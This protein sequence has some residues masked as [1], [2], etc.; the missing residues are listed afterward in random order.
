M[1]DRYTGG[2]KR[3][4]NSQRSSSTAEHYEK[5]PPGTSGHSHR[6][7]GK[8]KKGQTLRD[9]NYDFREKK[10]S[11]ATDSL[12]YVGLIEPRVAMPA[13]LQDRLQML[14]ERAQTMQSSSKPNDKKIK[15]G[16]YREEP[17]DIVRREQKASCINLFDSQ[18]E[19]EGS[20]FHDNDIHKV[21]EKALHARQRQP[22]SPD[23]ST[24]QVRAFTD[25]YKIPRKLSSSALEH[26]TPVSEEKER[27]QVAA[28]PPSS[29]STSP[30]DNIAD[31]K[32]SSLRPSVNSTT[33]DLCADGETDSEDYNGGN[34]SDRSPKGD[35]AF[36][37]KSRDVN[38][39]AKHFDEAADNAKKEEQKIAQ[40]IATIENDQPF[41]PQPLFTLSKAPSSSEGRKIK[42][43]V[44]LSDKT[45][46]EKRES[47]V[48]SVINFVKNSMF[49]KKKSA[50]AGQP[51]V[52]GASL[53][54]NKTRTARGTSLE[55]NKARTARG[56]SQE[57]SKTI[58]ASVASMT[59]PSKH[60]LSCDSSDESY[61]TPAR[62]RSGEKPVT[63]KTSMGYKKDDSLPARSSARKNSRTP[64]REVPTASYATRSSTRK[65]SIARKIPEVVDML[66]DSE[67]EQ[68]SYHRQCSICF[69]SSSQW[70]L[71]RT[72]W[73]ALTSL[74]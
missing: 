38:R 74:E 61:D 48:R 20:D 72:P 13:K 23:N 5:G 71:S 8:L 64:D 30:D 18:Y 37:K 35:E 29:C 9:V 41:V 1:S 14:R 28:K 67:D 45:A 6:A 70:F 31:I 55:S 53:E 50:N 4:R 10:F 21:P 22:D 25:S 39:S 57:A 3:R 32:R 49:G 12:G 17:L 62:P 60:R 42:E 59:T 26:T 46:D 36:S 16:K 11:E 58:T 33:I 52:P 44:A 19:R 47:P 68:V 63:K 69:R 65:T 15:K 27:N 34:N 51:I 66:E 7:S 56:A 54:S 43:F 24:K 2:K 40:A 73:R